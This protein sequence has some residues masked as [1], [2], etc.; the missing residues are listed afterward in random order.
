MTVTICAEHNLQSTALCLSLLRKLGVL[1][2]RPPTSRTTVLTHT[3]LLLH[4][5]SHPFSAHFR[6]HFNAHFI[7][8]FRIHFSPLC[9]LDIF[10][11]SFNP[12]LFHSSENFLRYSSFIL[13]NTCHTLYLLS[14]S[15]RTC[16]G[17]Q[18]WFVIAR[19]RA[20]FS[21]Q[22]PSI[23]TCDSPRLL[24]ENTETVT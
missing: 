3:Y 17:Y 11:S 8:Q 18:S 9:F 16:I 14:H 20:M 6:F 21:T 12:V 23:R 22:R 2:P 15:H 10:M 24:C 13:H 5:L 19:S 7:L 1:P 4:S